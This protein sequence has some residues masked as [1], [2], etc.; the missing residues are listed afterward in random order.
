MAFALAQNA[1]DTFVVFVAL[2]LGMASPYLLVSA[3]PRLAHLFPRPGLWMLSLRRIAALAMA[4][5]ALWL[6]KVLSDVSGPM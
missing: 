2:G 6:L 3:V 1:M 5:T 4:G